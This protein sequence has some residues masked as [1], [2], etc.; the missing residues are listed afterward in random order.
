M[1][2]STARPAVATRL[3]PRQRQRR[4]LSA[5]AEH[6]VAIALAIAF[7]A[8]FAI[9][10]LTAF[11]TQQQAGGGQLWPDPWV[12]NFGDVLKVMPFWRDF[13]NTVV[14]AGLACVGVVVSSVPVAYALARLRWRARDWVFMVV[15]ATMMI[16]AQV[17]S[18][19]LYV[20]YSKLG[21][22]GTLAPLI[23]PTFFGDAYSIFLLR[24]FFLTI[25][26]DLTEAAR[27]DGANDFQIMT[28]V[29]IPIAKPGIAAIGLFAF[30]WA[31]NDFYNPLLYT[32]DTNN[33]QTLA[34]ALSQLAKSAHEAAHQLQMA[35][36]LMFALPVIV[37]F[38]FAQK[39]FVEGISITG[40]KG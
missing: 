35:A 30:L 38:F 7:L 36:A 34:V 39:A 40:V 20:L 3:A 6:A 13:G 15:L 19:P 12:W 2:T 1:T 11:M 28:R 8:P 17:T 24:Q 22:M 25:P 14:Y 18:L 37:I 4:L 23:V 33:N 10:A 27:I 16:P 29:V 31:W 9:I 5:I 26:P 32:G 21:W